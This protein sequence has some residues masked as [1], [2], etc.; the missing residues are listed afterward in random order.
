[1][2][3]PAQ[4]VYVPVEYQINVTA[5]TSVETADLA[6]DLIVEEGEG[7]D[8]PP[9]FQSHY[10]RFYAVYDELAAL[11]ARLGD[12]FQP[13]LPVVTNPTADKISLPYT[14]RVFEL[15]NHAY[16]TLLFVLTSLYRNFDAN[17][18]GYPFLGTALQNLAFGPFM[19]MILRPLAEVLVHLRTEDRGARTAG[20]SFHLTAADERLIWPRAPQPV[21]LPGELTPGEQAAQAPQLANVD[22]FLDRMAH[23]VGELAALSTEKRL[24]KP[25]LDAAHEEWARRQLAFVHQNATAMANN[26]RRIYQVGEIPQ[27]A[28]T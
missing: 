12:A 3:N 11:Q 16:A 17:N 9:G 19:T 8:A 24:R 13:A 25:L 18:A 26:L 2:G 7:I 27:F 1:V 15:F 22:F 5:V 20:P 23:L 4:Q 21:R 6:I 28:L 10:T 14:L